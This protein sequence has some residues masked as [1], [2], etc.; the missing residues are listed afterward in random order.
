VSRLVTQPARASGEFTIGGD[1]PIV[2][3]GYGSMQFP[4]PLRRSHISKNTW[5]RALI[6][7][8]RAQVHNSPRAGS[9]LEPGHLPYQPAVREGA[10]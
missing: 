4:G 5:V 7:L 6:E 3:L 9:S 8:T 2:R 10:A 1:L